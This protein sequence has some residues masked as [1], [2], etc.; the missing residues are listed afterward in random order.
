LGSAFWT[1]PSGVVGA[2]E[3]LVDAAFWAG[4]AYAIDC[5]GAFSSAE[6]ANRIFLHQ[7]TSKGKNRR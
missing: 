5:F 3:A 4:V 7:T 1:L 2:C 6:L